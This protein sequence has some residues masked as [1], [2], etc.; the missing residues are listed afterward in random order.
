MKVDDATIEKR[1]THLEACQLQA[2]DT[3][4][5][6]DDYPEMDGDDAYAIQNLIKSRKLARGLT[7]GGMLC[8]GRAEARC[9]Q[10]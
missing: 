10:R 8:G 2:K 3:T 4:R 1:A 5:I 9:T 7:L 6:T